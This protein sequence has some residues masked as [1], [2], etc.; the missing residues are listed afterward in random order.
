[1][2]Q[3]DNKEDLPKEAPTQ[4]APTTKAIGYNSTG[5]STNQLSSPTC[6][7]MTDLVVQIGRSTDQL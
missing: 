7:Q 1:M 2:N 3:D 6:R 5:I 4:A